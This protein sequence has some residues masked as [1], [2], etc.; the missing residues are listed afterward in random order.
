MSLLV[1][2]SIEFFSNNKKSLYNLVCSVQFQFKQVSV[3]CNFF[4]VF[5]ISPI[6]FE[7][8]KNRINSL[9]TTKNQTN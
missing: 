6:Q 4:F 7:P 8:K 3:N 5:S 9:A 2:I 1:W